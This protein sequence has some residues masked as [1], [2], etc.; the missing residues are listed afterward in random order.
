[1]ATKPYFCIPIFRGMLTPIFPFFFLF[2][3]GSE[4]CSHNEVNWDRKTTLQPE[5]WQDSTPFFPPGNRAIFSTFWGDFLEKKDK[6]HWREFQN[7]DKYFSQRCDRIL[8]LFF[9]FRS[10][11]GQFSLHFGV[12]SWRKRTKSTGENSKSRQ[13]LQPETWQSSLPWSW[14]NV[15]WHTLLLGSTKKIAW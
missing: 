2:L 3:R 1:M 10:E 11:I 8:R 4:H 7:P 15:F 6:I 14:S 5:M 13:I 9:F 12:I